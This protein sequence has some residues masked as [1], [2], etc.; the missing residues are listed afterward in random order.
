MRLPPSVKNWISLAGVTIVLI[1]LFMIVF[2]FTVTVILHKQAA[3]LGLLVYILLPGV[4]IAGLLII[5]LGMYLKVRRE[6]KTGV[7]DVPGWPRIDLNETHQRNAALIFII[8][9]I[10]FL[11]LSAVGSYNA[12][13]YTESVS[14][15][16]TLC[17]GVMEPENVAHK[18]SA[19]ARVSCV[20]CHV[21][22]GVDWYVRSKLSG[23]YQVYAV[24]SNS[25]PRPIPTPIENLRPARAVCEQCHWPQKF[26]GRQYLVR[27]HFLQ[28]QANTRWDIGLTLKV[29]PPEQGSGYLS[30]IHWHVNSHVKI[31]YIAADDKREELPWV[32]YTN[33]D[34][35]KV[36]VFEDRENPPAPEL[37]KVE[38]PRL[39][40]CL[41][42][43]NRPSHSYLAPN[44]FLDQAMTSG[45]LPSDLPAFKAEA[46]RLC[47]R[48]YGTLDEASTAIR[49]GLTSLYRDKYPQVWQKRQAAVEG[50]IGVV[51]E[52]FARNIFPEM[53]VS[54][55]AYPDH[56]GHLESNGCFRC[57]NGRHQAA[58]GEVISNDC[59]LCHDIVDQGPPDA[60]EYAQINHSLTFRHPVDIDQ[61]WQET[62]CVECHQS[63]SP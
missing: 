30:G 61:A 23:L 1:S 5:P 45:Q 24:A 6:R 57:H 26:Y 59:N 18:N 32:R 40:D 58:S 49:Q 63:A 35:G 28:D 33:L 10:F 2:L 29:G 46:T 37:T 36:L 54:W 48:E 62:A 51:Q 4:M 38:K 15:C 12:F 44:E 9:T 50:A 14:F 16:G 31:E 20:A 47:S 42:C 3:Y 41:D 43:H 34:T 7:C 60:R 53:K 25:F 19:H 39:M 8:G 13:E 21:G 55:R 22:P 27:T 11:F 52:M 17:H 56:S